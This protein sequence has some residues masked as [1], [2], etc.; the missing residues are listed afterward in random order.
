MPTWVLDILGVRSFM[1]Q[2]HMVLMS[3]LVQG[4]MRW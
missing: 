4:A 3:E 1:W 2:E